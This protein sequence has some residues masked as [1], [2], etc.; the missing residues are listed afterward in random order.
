MTAMEIRHELHYDAPPAVVYA[1]LG[2]LRFRAE[3]CEAM[4]VAEHDVSVTGTSF[5]MDVRIDMAQRTSGLPSFARRIVGDTTRVIQSES[6]EAEKGAAL[7]VEI[8]G[9]P[10]HI[11][12]RITLAATGSGTTESFVGEATITIPLV[13]RRLEGLI[14]RLFI[15]GMDTEQAVGAR[16]L[17]ERDHA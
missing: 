8:P 5:G 11:R 7:Q 17:A 16:W 15:E 13:R 12:G 4:R 3:V 6:W 2:D 14:E 9:K 10:G 1:M